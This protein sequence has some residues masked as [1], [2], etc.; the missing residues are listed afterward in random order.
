MEEK[1]SGA[2]VIVEA[3]DKLRQLEPDE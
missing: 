1:K 3:L 2:D